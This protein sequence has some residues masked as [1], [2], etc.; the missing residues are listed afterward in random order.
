MIN[1]YSKKKTK[2]NF[3]KK[4]AKGTKIFVKKK[5]KKKR[6]YHCDQTL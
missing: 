6:Q 5:K 1:K 3:E 4:L 2:K